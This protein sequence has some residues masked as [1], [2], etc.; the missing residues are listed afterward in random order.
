MTTTIEQDQI[1]NLIN[2]QKLKNLEFIII[3]NTS[4]QTTVIGS[5]DVKLDRL[6]KNTN[7]LTFVNTP[8]NTITIKQA[9]QYLIEAN[10]VFTG[11]GGETGSFS[12]GIGININGVDVASVFNNKAKSLDGTFSISFAATCKVGDVIRLKAV[13]PAETASIYGANDTN[14]ALL[15]ISQI[16]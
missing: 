13:S 11:A 9:G 7:P 8:D 10:F 5:N 16:C 15:K 4:P 12:Y 6:V 1:H 2:L 14:C 3:A